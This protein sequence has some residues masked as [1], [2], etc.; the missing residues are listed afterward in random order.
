MIYTLALISMVLPTLYENG[1]PL[2]VD[3]KIVAVVYEID[4]PQPVA[5][6]TGYPGD[7]VSVEVPSDYGT[8]YAEAWTLDPIARSVQSETVTKEP[9]TGSCY[10]SWCHE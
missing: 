2:P 6:L 9:R 4:T 1:E 10:G 7:S 3:Q 5:A 8:W